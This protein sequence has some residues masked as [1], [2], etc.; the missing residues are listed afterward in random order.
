MRLRD[1]VIKTLDDG[2]L[3]IVLHLANQNIKNPNRK[4]ILPLSKL[5]AEAADKPQEFLSEHG[6]PRAAHGADNLKHLT[7]VSIDRVICTIGNIK[8]R[9]VSIDGEDTLITTATIKPFANK[10]DIFNL[11]MDNEDPGY[12]FGMRALGNYRNDSGGMQTYPRI[13]DVEKIITWDLIRADEGHAVIAPLFP[14][15]MDIINS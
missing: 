12:T 14:K 13:L 10:Q 4:T 9:L 7:E 1:R 8:C 15:V 11:A 6:H 2:S 5:I 3:E